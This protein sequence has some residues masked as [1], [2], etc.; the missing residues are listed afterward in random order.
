MVTVMSEPSSAA[1]TSGFRVTT[2]ISPGV[3]MGDFLRAIS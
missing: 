3:K 2:T 1:T